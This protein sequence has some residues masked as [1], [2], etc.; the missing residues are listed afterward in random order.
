[1]RGRPDIENLRRW[2]KICGV[3]LAVLML[4]VWENVQAERLEHRLSALRQE[5]DRLAYE[6]GRLQMQIHQYE[7]PRNLE[8]TAKKLGLVPLDPKRRVGIQP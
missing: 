4:R 5:S 1:M 2:A 3:V 6:N 7:S 8:A